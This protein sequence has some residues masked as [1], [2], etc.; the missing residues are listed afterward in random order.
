MLSSTWLVLGL[1]LGLGRGLGLGLGLGLGAGAGLEAQQ[2]RAEDL[3]PVKAI[4][5]IKGTPASREH[6]RRAARLVEEAKG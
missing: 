3:G 4:Q 6:E 5:S 2:Y 1:G